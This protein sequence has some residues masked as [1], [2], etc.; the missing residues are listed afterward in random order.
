MDWLG[1]YR[2]IAYLTDTGDVEI[3]IPIADYDIT[4]DTTSAS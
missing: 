2:A 1:A 3:N 4:Y